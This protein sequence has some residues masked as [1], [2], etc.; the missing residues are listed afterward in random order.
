MTERVQAFLLRNTTSLQYL[1][2][3]RLAKR[4]G[5]IGKIFK[6]LEIGKRQYSQHAH[7][8]VAKMANW[9]WMKTLSI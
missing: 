1:V 7:L 2:N 9:A 4:S 3:E 6:Y 8:R 5:V